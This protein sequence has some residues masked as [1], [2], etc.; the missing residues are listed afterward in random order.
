MSVLDDLATRYGTDKGPSIGGKYGHHYTKRYKQ[1][2]EEIRHD[3]LTI[4]EL[5]WGGHE[6]PD[7]GGASA[8][9]WR[10][11]FPNSTV[12]CIDIEDKVITKA[13]DGIHFRQGSQGDKEF[14]DALAEEFGGFDIIIDDASHLSSLTI[15]S[16]TY[17]YPHLKPGGFYAVEDMHMAY[18]DHYY[19]KKEANGNPALP[20]SDGSMTSMQYFKRLTDEVNFKNRWGNEMDL[21]QE[22]YS[23]GFDLE[24]VHF[25]FNLVVVRKSD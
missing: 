6:N 23:L 11:Y 16:W 17:L 3:K 4:L 20:T 24:W 21:F 13:H 22:K 18:H 25:Y 9:M 1:Y 15:A 19:G 14:L 12:V 8:Q 10:D 7:K 5:C 2:F